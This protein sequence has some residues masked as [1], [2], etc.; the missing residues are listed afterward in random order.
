MTTV[1]DQGVAAGR[2]VAA[3]P[4]AAP[5]WS[6]L[7]HCLA[8]AFL[9]PPANLPASAWCEALA[10]DLTDLGRELDL[11]L[12]AAVVALHRAGS[13]ST[14]DEPW[15]VEYS[16]LFLVPPVPVTLN[17]GIYLEGGLAGVSAQMMTQ[18]YQSAGL[19]QREAFRDL[20]DH[21]A[22]QLEFVG[23]LL[24]RSAAE[25][26]DAFAMAQEFTEGFVAQWVGPLRAACLKASDSHSAAAVYATLAGVL[27]VTTDRIVN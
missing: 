2:T 18:C 17:T 20:P 11:D 14:D 3:N 9:P 6:D 21:A 22:I 25:D 27:Q 12:D 10:D 19:S 7:L 1:H 15:L 24:A 4:L 16:R 8:R 26:D 13:G 5:L 23:A